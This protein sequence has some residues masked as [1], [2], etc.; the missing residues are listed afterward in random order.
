MWVRMNCIPMGG[1]FS[2]Q[3]AGVHSVW[4]VYQHRNLFRQLG[5][6]TVSPEGIPLWSGQWGR[7][8]MCQFRDNILVATGCPRARQ[9]ALIETIRTILKTAWCL[10]VE[11]D[12]ISPQQ[13]TCTAQCCGPVR[14]AVDVVMTLCPPPGEGMRFQRTSSTQT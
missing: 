8:A 1:P 14:K 4:R 3:G 11:C 10:E 13:A 5:A 7:V 12:C 9:A 6:L 2:A